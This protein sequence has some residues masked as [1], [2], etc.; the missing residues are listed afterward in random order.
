M[1]MLAAECLLHG[2]RMGATLEQT[3]QLQHE[4]LHLGWGFTALCALCMALI[5]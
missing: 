4:M 2:P 1:N 5:T 3:M